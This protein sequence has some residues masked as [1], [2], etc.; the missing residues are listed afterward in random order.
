MTDRCPR[1]YSSYCCGVDYAEEVEKLRAVL[2]KIADMPLTQSWQQHFYDAVK[3]AQDAL[4]EDRD[5]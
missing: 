4:Q 1:C 2:Q 3:I 5:D